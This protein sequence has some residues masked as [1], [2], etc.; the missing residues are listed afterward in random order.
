MR[1]YC[2]E[3][4]GQQKNI[5]KLSVCYNFFLHFMHCMQIVLEPLLHTSVSVCPVPCTLTLLREES[6]QGS[7]SLLASA[8]T[9]CLESVELNTHSQQQQLVLV[10]YFFFQS[11]MTTLQS[12]TIEN[13][14][15]VKIIIPYVTIWI[16]YSLILV[17]QI[18]LI[19]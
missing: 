10:D 15:S 8:G 6:D 9:A 18:T 14:H 17:V 3:E 11:R 7:Q 16:C 4:I 13:I 12:V 19:T 5:V 2:F 1:E